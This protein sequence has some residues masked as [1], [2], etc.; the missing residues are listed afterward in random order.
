VP[1]SYY[2]KIHVKYHGQQVLR[3]FLTATNEATVIS[4]SYC[5]RVVRAASQFLRHSQVISLNF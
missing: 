4:H 1:Q 5:T 2:G 3:I